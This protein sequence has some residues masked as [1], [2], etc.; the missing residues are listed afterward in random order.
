[1]GM[2]AVGESATSAGDAAEDE[3]E[4]VNDEESIVHH[5][6]SVGDEEVLVRVNTPIKFIFSH[7]LQ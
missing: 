6:A 1:M 5:T 4:E 7:S 3:S 2:A